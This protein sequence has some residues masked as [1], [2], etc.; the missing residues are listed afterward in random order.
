M[1]HLLDHWPAVVDRLA[2]ADRILLMLDF[3]GTLA[4][5]VAHPPEARIALES[6]A[7]LGKLAEC[8]RVRLA[9]VSGRAVRDMQALVGL[10][11]IQYVGS[12]GREWLPPRPRDTTEDAGRRQAVGALCERLASKLDHVRGFVLEDKGVSAA[13]HYRNAPPETWEPIR[14]TVRKAVRDSGG[15]QVREGKMVLDITPADGVNKGTAV[16]ALLASHGG[17]PVYFG[18]DST[19]EDAFRALP[20]G[21]VTVYVGPP[22]A[23]SAARYRVADPEEVGRALGRFLPLVR[24]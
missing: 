22:S 18:D 10:S 16:L 7:T 9:I 2:R 5:I 23:P 8:S 14:R 12:H 3:D 13:A 24:E 6:A 19:D 1:R 21:A 20:D 4:P 17:Q 11:G 15:L